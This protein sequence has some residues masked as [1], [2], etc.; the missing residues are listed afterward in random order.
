MFWFNLLNNS[1]RNP[2]AFYRLSELYRDKGDTNKSL[3]SLKQSAS[4]GWM[5][6]EE[7]LGTAYLYG[8]YNGNAISKNTSEAK[9]L[10]KKAHDHGSK[11]AEGIYCSSL[12][13]AKQKTCK[14]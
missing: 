11:T 14:F 10:L 2:K 1:S 13:K 7:G 4:L 3:D 6:P 5:V 9:K 12:P 8:H